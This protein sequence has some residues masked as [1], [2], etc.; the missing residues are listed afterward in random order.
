MSQFAP[1]YR[2]RSLRTGMGLLLLANCLCI[3]LSVSAA[4]SASPCRELLGEAPQFLRVQP[5]LRPRRRPLG[6]DTAAAT[7]AAK[8]TWGLADISNR[9]A[10]KNFFNKV[11]VAVVC[12]PLL[13][14]H[15]E[16]QPPRPAGVQCLGGHRSR[17]D[18][19]HQQLQ[20]RHLVSGVS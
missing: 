17:L 20:R 19:Q 9:T 12:A 6:W 14:S 16:Q 7:T 5:R 15:L 8:T 18:G 1:V 13:Q 10:V 11:S 3:L 2:Y 4:A